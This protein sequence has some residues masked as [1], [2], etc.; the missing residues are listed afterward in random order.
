MDAYK[1][2]CRF[3]WYSGKCFRFAVSG[4]YKSSLN[5]GGIL[6]AGVIGAAADVNGFS[7]IPGEGWQGVVASGLI[8]TAVAFLVIFLARLIFVAPFVIHRDGQWHGNKFVYREP[9]LAIH[10]Y[11][12][13][14]ENNRLFHFR[15]PDAPPFSTIT[16]WIEAER[17]MN[18]YSLWIEPHPH[19]RDFKTHSDHTYGGGS[20]QLN[21]N[22]D[23]YFK[24]FTHPGNDPFSIRVYIRAWEERY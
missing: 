22:R 11:M 21:K 7:L 18:F 15:F 23:L 6:G 2:Y 8:Y 24:S 9:K 17:P 19:I 10:V 16:Y 1:R 20:F 5:W 12:S 14:K 3:C 13:A 4:A